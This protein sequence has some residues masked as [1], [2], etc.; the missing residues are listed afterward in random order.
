MELKVTRENINVLQ[1]QGNAERWAVSWAWCSWL[2]K[3][4]VVAMALKPQ[5]LIPSHT[6]KVYW[7]SLRAFMRRVIFTNIYLISS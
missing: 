6:F 4:Q 1:A 5:V 2:P 3:Q 7:E